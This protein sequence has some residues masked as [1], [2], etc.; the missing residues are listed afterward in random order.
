MQAGALSV[1]F[2][3]TGLRQP[4]NCSHLRQEHHRDSSWGSTCPW[5]VPLCGGCPGRPHTRTRLLVPVPV[6]LSARHSARVSKCNTIYWQGLG[7]NSVA[8]TLCW[9]ANQCWCTDSLCSSFSCSSTKAMLP[10]PEPPCSVVAHEC[11]Q[12]KARSERQWCYMVTTL[13]KIGS[14]TLRL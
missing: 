13:S 14:K 3:G 11:K 4:R 9:P 5:S 12:P 8:K 7:C 2:S 1:S 10:W 6:S